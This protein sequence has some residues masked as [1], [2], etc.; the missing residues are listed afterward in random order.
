[1]KSIWIV[2]APDGVGKDTAVN[3]LQEQWSTVISNDI[4]VEFRR[5]PGGT[6]M[7]EGVRRLLINN[8]DIQPGAELALFW[9]GRLQLW[10][11][12]MIPFLQ[13]NERA[14]VILNRSY[15]STVAYQLYGRSARPAL[16]D[17]CY[18]LIRM[19]LD[20]V[21]QAVPTAQIHHLYLNLSVEESLIRMGRREEIGSQAADDIKQFDG[22]AF[23][24]KVR[25]G[26][27]AYYEKIQNAG[28]VLLHAVPETVD[29]V[30]ASPSKEVVFDSVVRAIRN[31][32]E[33]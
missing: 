8:D 22:A 3:T 30:D 11:Q 20:I 27:N 28:S 21:H 32:L 26:Y 16:V 10:E 5:E 25:D 12:V 1:M 31:R 17:A 15:P 6:E 23:Q 18:Y 7:G 9:A 2:E 33:L 19:L 24:Q 13:K 14:V 29:I 4:A